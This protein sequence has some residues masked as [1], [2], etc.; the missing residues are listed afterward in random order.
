MTTTG[1]RRAL[2]AEPLF[3]VAVDA[4]HDHDQRPSHYLLVTREFRD[5]EYG[6]EYGDDCTVEADDDYTVKGDDDYDYT[7]EGYDDL[8]HARADML[9]FEESGIFDNW[10]GQWVDEPYFVDELDM[11]A[12]GSAPYAARPVDDPWR[13]AMAPIIATCPACQARK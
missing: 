2:D 12:E 6:D 1:Y 9:L 3:D 4:H 7:F 10:T 8:D 11:F 5:Y 13:A